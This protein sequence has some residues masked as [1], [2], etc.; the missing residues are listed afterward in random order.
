MSKS[1]WHRRSPME[2]TDMV[3]LLFRVSIL[4][5]PIIGASATCFNT[6]E[7]GGPG[8]LWWPNTDPNFFIAWAAGI[9]FYPGDCLQFNVYIAGYVYQLSE[10]DYQTCTLSNPLSAWNDAY[11]ILGPF[12]TQ[13]SY[14]VTFYFSAQLTEH[15][16]EGMKF[17]AT[18]SDPSSTPPPP[19]TTTVTAPSAPSDTSPSPPSNTSPSTPSST[20]P[21]TGSETP[22]GTLLATPPSSAP[23]STKSIAGIV[24]GVVAAL[25]GG[26]GLTYRFRNNFT[27]C[28]FNH[29]GAG[30]EGGNGAGNGAGN[31]VR[32]GAGHGVRHG[33]GNGV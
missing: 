17:A 21:A 25:T 16:E 10:S 30:N 4:L 1:T 11:Y 31:K 2:H 32:H 5:A 22:F 12:P 15:C 27:C 7:V 9:T 29:N 8:I 23:L 6:Y 26:A 33:V 18:V 19:L 20:S 24:A 28:V 3:H 14:P 13:S